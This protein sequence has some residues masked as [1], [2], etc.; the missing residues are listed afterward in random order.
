[1]FP[2]MVGDPNDPNRRYDP[3]VSGTW[4]A[5]LRNGFRLALV[6]SVLMLLTAMVALSA[7]FPLGADE[8]FRAP[9]MR[10][11]RFVAFGNIVLALGLVACAAQ[12]QQGSRAARRAM[13]GCAAASIFLN[14]AGFALKVTSWA[15]FLIAILLAVAMWLVFRPV[16]NGYFDERHSLWRGVS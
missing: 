10:N 3:E 9:F 7:G 2:T 1:M 4:P 15:S 5:A 11:M 8:A 14:L 12:L 16:A 13:A 6:A